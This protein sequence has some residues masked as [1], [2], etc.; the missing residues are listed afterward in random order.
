M[1]VFER[2]FG[3][4]SDLISLNILFCVLPPPSPRGAPAPTLLRALRP[5]SLCQAVSLAES[6]FCSSP[7]S[8]F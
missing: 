3:A 2:K 8:E 1:D 7:S 6:V 4:C 5:R